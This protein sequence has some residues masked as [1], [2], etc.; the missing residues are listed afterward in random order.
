MAPSGTPLSDAQIANYW[1]DGYLSEIDVLTIDQAQQA[2]TKLID[3]EASELAKDPIRWSDENHQPWQEPGSPGWHWFMGMCTH[4]TII[5]A[6]SQLLGP[7]LLIRNADIFV[8]VAHSSRAIRWHTDTTASTEDAGRMLTAWLALT[9]SMEE[10]GCMEWAKGSHRLPLPPEVKDKHSLALSPE[11]YEML[12]NLPKISNLLHPGQMSL[13][14]FRTLHRSGG[15]ITRHPRIG[16][17][18]RF[19]AADTPLDAAE[20]GTGLLVSGE[21]TPGHFELRKRIRVTWN[22]SETAQLVS[23]ATLSDFG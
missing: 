4:P 20:S 19:M 22:R 11:S 17:V 18:I 2:K 5:G 15:N 1:A 21:N 3:L 14:H 6:V 9:D 12:E 7:N 13:H 23:A 8:K 16:L 10:N